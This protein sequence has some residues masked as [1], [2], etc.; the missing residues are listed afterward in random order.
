VETDVRQAIQSLALQADQTVIVDQIVAGTTSASLSDVP[1]EEA[2]RIVLMPLGYL[3]VRRA[4]RYY[5]GAPIPDSALFPYLADTFEFRPKHID[6]LELVELLQL[7]AKPFVRATASSRMIIVNA[8]HQIAT[9]IL[10]DL[11]RADEPP[12]QVVLEAII[13]AYA[14]KDR[15]QFGLDFAGGG[16]AGGDFWNASLTALSGGGRLGPVDMDQLK[17][18]E[19]TSVFLHALDSEGYVSVRAAPRVMAQSG[20]RAV[21]TIGQETYFTLGDENNLLRSLKP[22]QT[23]IIL[24]II[25]HIHGSNVTVEIERAEVSDE[26]RPSQIVASGSDG[27][28]PTVSTRRVSTTV[29]VKD[30]HTI[31]IGGLVMRRKVERVVKVPILGDIPLLGRLFQRIDELEEEIEVAIFLSPRIVRSP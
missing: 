18:F 31:V 21:I 2:L 13:C 4:D 1:F 24:N 3:V 10:R 23:G 28:L 16:E 9:R 6:P 7:D 12:P 19:F 8:P 15:L 11:V 25:P 22:V 26:I 5:V 29:H 30:G 20:K 27:L 14:P 17:S